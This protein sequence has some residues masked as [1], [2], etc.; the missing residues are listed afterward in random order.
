MNLDVAARRESERWEWQFRTYGPKM[1]PRF[2]KRHPALAL[3]SIWPERVLR[4]E[5]EGQ[6]RREMLKKCLKAALARREGNV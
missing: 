6:A 2:F 5:L 4:A 3:W 1:I